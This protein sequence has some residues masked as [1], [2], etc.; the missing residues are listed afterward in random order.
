MPASC[1]QEPSLEK[2]AVQDYLATVVLHPKAGPLKF[3]PEQSLRVVEAFKSAGYEPAMYSHL[4]NA[5]PNCCE[6]GCMRPPLTS[7]AFC[8]CACAVGFMN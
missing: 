5:N 2:V 6:A 3:T 7:V 4:A 1:Q 8:P